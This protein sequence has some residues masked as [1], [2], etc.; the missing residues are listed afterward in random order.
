MCKK[1][2]LTG[3]TETVMKCCVVICDG[4]ADELSRAN[5][6]LTPIETAH[7]PWLDH[8]ATKGRSGLVHTVPENHY[9]GSEIA[10]LTILGYP[11][12]ILPNGRGYMEALGCG[13]DIP[14]DTTVF[15]RYTINNPNI[16]QSDLRNIFPNLIFHPLNASKGLVYDSRSLHPGE[17]TPEI[18]FWS[19]DKK[20]VFP[21]LPFQRSAPQGIRSAMICAV[22]LLKGIAIATGIDYVVPRGATGD[23]DTDYATKASAAIRA[24]EDH[25]IVI[26]HVEA[27]DYASHA[28]DF[29][30]KVDA[31][32]KI[33]QLIIAPLFHKTETEGGELTL[34]VLPDHPALCRTG[35]HTSGKVPLI[36][37]NPKNT[38]DST[39][40]YSEKEAIRGDIKNLSELYQLYEKL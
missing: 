13:L 5:D 23:T 34:V 14:S 29:H 3:T 40:C 4:M 19:H 21:S 6:R 25:E 11:P 10:I 24:L 18:T 7:T 27:C 17:G 12:E 33:D 16:T 32:E 37:F 31:I 1:N 38:P 22:P 30:A 15:A 2:H 39:V 26:L 8:L 36:I 35:E 28:K 9:P 20:R